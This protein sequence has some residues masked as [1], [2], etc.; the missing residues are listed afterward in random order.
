MVS[1]GNF[2]K[3]IV[4]WT[5]VWVV[6]G[7]LSQGYDLKLKDERGYQKK[8]K[9]DRKG[10]GK[11]GAV[12]SKPCLC[13]LQQNYP[14]PD[15]MPFPVDV[16]TSPSRKQ[17]TEQHIGTFLFLVAPLLHNGRKLFRCRSYLDYMV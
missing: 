11:R 15:E 4:G 2:H 3:V 14:R 8:V 16:S 17:A 6:V 9:K 5:V 13:T 1:F 10:G 7:K 12:V